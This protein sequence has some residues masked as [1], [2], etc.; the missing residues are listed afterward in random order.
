MGKNADEQN[1][2]EKTVFST[3]EAAQICSVSQQTII[4]CFDSGRLQGFRVPGSKFR[5]I[6]REELVRFMRANG[7]PLG[8]IEGTVRRVLCIVEEPSPI[9]I[10][11][12]AVADRN[13]LDLRTA[14]NAYDAGA[15]TVEFRPHLILLDDG[16]EQVPLAMLCERIARLD[17]PEKPRVV[18]VG[19]I[20]TGDERDERTRAGADGVIAL[21][22][23]DKEL[24][25]S[26]LRWIDADAGETGDG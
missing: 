5:R 24:I 12:D 25:E 15:L 9:T 18:C 14:T 20:G 8:A 4:R 2:S 7:I 3:G 1:W 19:R 13:R 26:A 22:M 10:V 21:P 6:P 11:A 23:P 16:M 17:S